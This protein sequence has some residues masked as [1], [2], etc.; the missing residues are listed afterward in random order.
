M[1]DFLETLVTEAK[2]TI[3]RGYYKIPFKLRHKTKSLRRAII[4]S[5]RTPII[6]EIKLASPTLGSFTDDAHI[7][8]IA[9]MMVEGGA[10]GISILTEPKF[11]KGSLKNFVKVRERVDLPLLMKD[12]VLNPIQ[13]DA[14]YNI[15]ADAI[16]LVKTI[17]DRGLSEHDL[18]KMIEY[19]HYKGMEVLLE[20]HVEEEFATALETEADII[21]INNRNLQTLEV[22]I[23]TTRSILQ[24]VCPKDKVIISESG[25]GARSE[26]LYLKKFDVDA[27]L[28]GSSLMK[29]ENLRDK[30]E[31]F[32]TL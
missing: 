20:T 29:A 14:G 9:S 31:E 5:K 17:Y 4:S 16:L 22:N 27:F 25:I 23:D 11:F 15:G 2:D 19:I 13:I 26:I 30:L 6:A 18:S 7:E 28:I 1:A 32:V 8:E 21:G 12:V 10:V 24:N 3:R